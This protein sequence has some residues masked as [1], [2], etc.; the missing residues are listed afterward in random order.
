MKIPVI[1][2]FLL[3]LTV[4][5]NAQVSRGVVKEG[6]TLDSKI[7]GAKVRYTIYLPFDY[8]TS[9]RF[10]PVVYLLH[11]YTDNDMAWIQFGEAHLIADEAIASREIPPMIIVMPDAGVSWY[12]N[13]YN[14]SVRYE[15][16]FF[17][18][19]LPYIESHYRIRAEKNYRGIAGLSMGGFGTLVY[20][21]RHPEQFVAGAALSSAVNTTEQFIA[22]DDRGWGRWP[23]AIYGA[24]SGE[25]RI[26]NHLL[27]YQPIR[28][29]ETVDVEK[30]KSVRIYLDCGDDDYLTIG[31]AMLH[32]ALTQRQIPHE[33][34]VRD[35]SHAWSY[36]RSGLLEALKFIGASFHKP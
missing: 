19:F 3:A 5:A 12:I 4:A 36:W 21:M 25:A 33:Y 8:E 7:M 9:S 27:S 28:M 10:Y 17:Q 20:I 23:T 24:G 30:L 32:V 35:G 31:N 2:S 18:E 13:N 11:G 22:M 29:A 26:T 15:D 34:R 6:L 16:F 14:N 1:L